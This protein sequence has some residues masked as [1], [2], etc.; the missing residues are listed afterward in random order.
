MLETRQNQKSE[1]ASVFNVPGHMVGVNGDD[2]GKSSV[3]Q[4]SIEFKLFCLD[5][6]ATTWEQEL[7]RKLF[8]NVGRTAKKYFAGFDFRK[9]LYPDAASRSALY[10]SGK[11]WGYMTTNDIR[12]LEGMNPIPDTGDRLWMPTNMVDADQTAAHADAVQDGL[13]DGTLAATPAGTTPVGSHPA[14]KDKMKMQKQAQ[15]AQADQ[16]AANAKIAAKVAAA[17]GNKSNDPNNPQ[18]KLNKNQNGSSASKK[19]PA[20]QKRDDAVKAFSIL[21]RDAVGRAAHRSK[22][23]V[24]DY[25]AIFGPVAIGMA[26]LMFDEPIDTTEFITGYTNEIFT[27]SAKWNKEDLDAVAAQEQE[28]LLDLLEIA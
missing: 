13:K 23:T 10:G 27:R 9:L 8:P 20:K 1:V 21:Y 19:A 11:Q 24:E 5:P 22:A 26:Q 3:E 7:S 25:R 14:V 18:A 4:S 12:E 15:Q 28:S 6:W 2:A 16:S 17:N